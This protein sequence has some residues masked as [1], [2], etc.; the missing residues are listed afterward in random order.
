MNLKEFANNRK[1]LY[2][3]IELLNEAY[4]NEDFSKALDLIKSLLKKHTNYSKIL[5]LQPIETLM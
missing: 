1:E 2:A 5:K 4:K 3:N